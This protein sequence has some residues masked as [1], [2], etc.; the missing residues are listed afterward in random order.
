MP[1]LNNQA[2]L[3]ALTTA[4]QRFIQQEDTKELFNS[5]LEVLLGLTQS[6][7]GF[8][9]EVRYDRDAPYLKT[10]A[11]TNIAWNEATRRFYEEGAPRGLEFTNLKTLF[12]QVIVTQAPVIANSPYTDPRRGGLPTGHPKMNAFLGLPFFADNR[13]N[14]MVGIANRPGGYDEQICR[15]LEPFLATCTALI[16][17]YRHLRKRQEYQQR[18]E[19]TIASLEQANDELGTF[20]YRT[21]HDLRGPLVSSIGLLELID[22]SLQSGETELAHAAVGQAQKALGSLEKLVCDILSLTEV[23]HAANDSEDIN[24]SELID[25]QWRKAAQQEGG[26]VVVLNTSLEVR[27]IKANRIRLEHVVYNLMSNA[28]KYRRPEASPPSLS[29]RVSSGDGDVSFCFDDNGLGIPPEFHGEMFTMFRRFHPRH[30]VGSGLG[31]YLIRKSITAMRGTISYAP[32]DPGSRFEFQLPLSA[33][34]TQER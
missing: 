29:L 4:Q 28:I 25:A 8:I 12:G 24:L 7:Y 27:S 6:E 1:H 5:L 3:A 34:N 15:E 17:G 2:L 19:A 33:T 16:E 32:R 13:L 23:S 30:S 21:S 10:H 20:A 9:G 11:I 26:G 14:G 18:L 31:L 22:S